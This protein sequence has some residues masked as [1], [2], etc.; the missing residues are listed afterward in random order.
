M[1][2]Q[3]A[4]EAL[5]S[6]CTRVIMDPEAT[7]ESKDHANYVLVYIADGSMLSITRLRGIILPPELAEQ[8]RLPGEP[9]EK[10]FCAMT[11]ARL[12]F[13]TYY[14]AFAHG[15]T[16]AGDYPD[17]EFVIMK[18]VAAIP[19]PPRPMAGGYYW[20]RSHDSWMRTTYGNDDG[21]EIV[22]VIDDGK[23]ICLRRRRDGASMAS[24]SLILG[25]FDGP[26]TRDENTSPRP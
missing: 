21:W 8:K 3:T 1:P 4:L 7:E 19:R 5:K 9:C 15:K 16:L 13:T 12:K 26:I 2:D 23:A 25:E 10:F 11:S 22:E 20:Y 6:I 17:R 14:E 18:S 24:I